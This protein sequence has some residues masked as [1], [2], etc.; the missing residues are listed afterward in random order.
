MSF[1][2]VQRLTFGRHETCFLLNWEK[3]HCDTLDAWKTFMEFPLVHTLRLSC[4]RNIPP[5]I[6]TVCK[7]L[8]S[9]S[10]DR[11]SS[12]SNPPNVECYRIIKLARLRGTAGEDSIEPLF[13]PRGPS[14]SLIID[15]CALT[16]VHIS[17]AGHATGGV[18]IFEYPGNLS[19]LCIDTCMSSLCDCC[20]ERS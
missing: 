14:K 13:F 1:K 15:V 18:G 3:V 10:L 20:H 19:K 8:K 16:H 5:S 11:G 7:G 4:I 2:K 12:F 17:L 6:L 9:L